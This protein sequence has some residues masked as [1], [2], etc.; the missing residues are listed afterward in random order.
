MNFEDRCGK[1]R[2][3]EIYQ[4]EFCQNNLLPPAIDY[5]PNL[6]QTM[7]LNETP[8]QDTFT[9]SRATWPVS[10]PV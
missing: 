6:E 1:R 3:E 10:L 5:R 9:R 8:Y 7:A 2:G 4:K